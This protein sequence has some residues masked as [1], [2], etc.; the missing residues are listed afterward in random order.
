MTTMG[1]AS[2]RSL[3]RSSRSTGVENEEVRSARSA[4]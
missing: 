2:A 1:S 3:L 4:R